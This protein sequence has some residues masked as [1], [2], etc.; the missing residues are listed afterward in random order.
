MDQSEKFS[1]YLFAKMGPPIAGNA[2]AECPRKTTDSCEAPVELTGAR[3]WLS[4]NLMLLLT[5]SGVLFGVI[6]GEQYLSHIMLH[7]VCK[8]VCVVVRTIV[9]GYARAQNVGEVCPCPRVCVCV[10]TLAF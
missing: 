8:S 6:L 1:D 5:L 10:C 9:Q 2:D 7:I 4:D 3:K